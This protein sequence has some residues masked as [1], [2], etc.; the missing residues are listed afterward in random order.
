MRVH[1]CVCASKYVK[2]TQCISC[3]LVVLIK[4]I[5]IAEYHSQYNGNEKHLPKTE[6]Y[7]HQLIDD[8]SWRQQFL[9]LL[10]S[11]LL[12]VF[13]SLKSSASWASFPLDPQR[14]GRCLFEEWRADI[15]LITDIV[16]SL[17][18]YGFL[19]P[20]EFK[21]QGN[22]RSIAF[23]RSKVP[24][25]LLHSALVSLVHWKLWSKDPHTGKIHLLSCCISLVSCFCR[26][27]SS[28]FLLS[29][30]THCWIHLFT[31]SLLQ[32]YYASQ[33]KIR[34]VEILAQS[35]AYFTKM[36]LLYSS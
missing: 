3:T 30:C 25:L 20:A 27:S 9:H 6:A 11:N 33:L 15:H 36:V 21:T 8:M 24:S 10:H 31:L 5:K 35:P 34:V 22:L 32:N 1:I 28:P 18:C 12:T 17:W 29:S 19:I 26:G 13:V 4:K 23:H 16:F 14:K 7:V 2:I